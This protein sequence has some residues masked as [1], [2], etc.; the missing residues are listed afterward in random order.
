MKSI[1][2]LLL[3]LSRQDIKL[4]VEGGLLR[5]KAPQ[6]TLNPAI[7]AEIVDRK[8]EI[9][10]FLQ[11]TASSA[12]VQILPAPRD[13][14]MPLSFAQQRLWFIN[15]LE[16]N[17]STYN[18]PGAI[19]LTGQLD[20]VSLERTLQEIIRRHEALRTNFISHNG[21]PIQVIQ[22]NNAWQMTSIDLQD[23]PT[24]EREEK[25]Q[26][27]ATVDAEKP[28]A[29]DTDSLIRATLIIATETEHILLLTMH[30]I[31]S[32]GWSM[33]VLVEEIAVLYEAFVRCESSP[34]P[35][36]EIQYV[37]FA[38]WQRQWLQ[39]EILERQ[40]TYWQ[41]QL[42]NAP[43]LLE[44]PTDRPRPPVQ[45]FR[46]AEQ[47]FIIPADL[48]SAL[49]SLSR[50]EEVTLF[51]TLLAAFDILLARYTGQIDILIGSGIA[52]RHHGQLEGLI[53]FFVNTLVLRTDLSGNPSFRELLGRV[54][55]MVL[56][57]YDHQDLP[58][59]MLVDVLKPE[60]SPSH[61]P[62]FQVAFVL[63]NAPVSEI[64]LAGLTLSTLTTEH[65][66]AKLD[67]TLSLEQ[68]NDELIGSWEY[69]TDLF[70]DDTITR[71]AGHFQT[72]LAGIVADP[73][74]PIARL[75]LLTVTEQNQLLHE[76]N[77]TQTDYPQDRCVHQLFE[78]QAQQTPNTM[79]VVC[80]DRHLT[81]SELNVRANQLANYL[82]ELGVKPSMLVG[83]CVDRSID[84]IVGILGILKAGGAYVPLDPTY[85]LERLSFMLSD[86]QVQVLL[87][88]QQLVAGL[89]THQATVVC[90]DADWQNI[91]QHQL[92]NLSVN[93]TSADLAYIIYTSGSTGTPK[94]VMVSH[95]GLCNLAKA[96]IALFGI[97]ATSKIL[98]FASLSFDASIW[99][100]VMGLTSGAT[101]YVDT[102]E[103]LLPGHALW[104]YLHTRQITHVV[105]PPAALAVLPLEP[106]PH[107]QVII[108]G[109]EACPQE[110][111]AQWSQG[112]SFFNAYGPTEG[113]VCATV[114]EP[115]DGRTAT[116]IGRPIQNVEVYIFNSDLQPL[117]IGVS[118]ELHIG[119]AGLAQG[120]LNRPEL[121]AAKFIPHPFSDNPQARLYKTGD[122]AR[123]LPDGNIEYLGRI[124]HQVKIRGFRI[125]LEEIEALLGQYPGVQQTAVIAREDREHDKRLVAYVVADRHAPDRHLPQSDARQSQYIADWQNLY[126]Q[127]YQKLPTD[128]DLTFNIAGWNSSYT[129]SPIPAA[130]MK[131]WVDCTVEQ[132]LTL[133][134]QRVL[135]IG[136]GSG[137]LLSQ[138]APHCHEYWG[139]DYSAAALQ[140]IEQM[141]QQVAG[142]ENV[143]TL[144]R[145]ADDFHGIEPASFDTVIINSVVQYFPSVTYL[146]RVLEQAVA[147]VRAGGHVLIGDVRNLLLLDTYILSVQLHQ[148]SD[149][150]SLSQLQQ[151]VQQRMMQE[152]ELLVDPEFFLALQ[153]HLPRISHVRI[154]PKRGVYHNELTKFRYEVMLEIEGCPSPSNHATPIAWLDWQT[155]PLTVA[156]IRQRLVHTQPEIFGISHI[157]NGRV[158]TEMQAW[159]LLRDEAPELETVQDLRQTLS[160]SKSAGIDPAELWNLSQELSYTLNLSWSNSNSDG[161]YDAVFQLPSITTQLDL[162]PVKSSFQTWDLYGSNP[163]QGELAK[164]LIP[165]LR[166]FLTDKLPNY[167]VPSAFML[168]ETM[169]L[170]ANGKIDRRKLPVPEISRNQLAVGFVAPRNPTE[171]MLA[172]VWAE[173]L[174]IE[175]IGIYDNF[176]A[177]GGHSLLGTQLISRVKN[178]FNIDLPL[179]SLFEAAT[180][181]KLAE[182]IQQLQQT[183][184]AVSQPPIQV[185]SRSEPI[186]LS[187]AQQRLWFFDRL[188]PNSSAYNM[189]GAVRLQG[190]LDLVVLERALQEIVR[191]HEFLRTN[192][193]SQDGQPIQVIHQSGSWQMTSIDLQHLPVSTREEKIQQLAAV[194][195]EQPF[196]L[197]TDPLMRAKLLL[198][199]ATERILLLTMHHIISDGWS[200]G[201]FVK[202][203]AALYSAFVQGESSPLPELTIQYADFAVWQR[204]WLQGET[205]DR[206]LGY[207]QQQLA[208]IPELSQLPTDRPRPSVQTYQGATESFTLGQELTEQLQALSRQTD[209]T[210]FMTLLATFATLLYRY[211]GESD[212]VIGSPIANRNRS[213]I[214]SLIGF[215][216]N[217][218]VLRTRLEEHLSFEQL[219]KQVRATTLKAY[220]HQ[221]LSFEQ[222]VEALQPQRSMSHS[223]L[224]QVMFVLQNTPMGEIKLPGVRLSELNASSTIAKFDLALS[225]TETHLGLDC[226]WEYNTDLFD[227][228]TIERM[229]I[230]FENLLAAIVENPRQ[231]VSELPLLSET[232]R[233][234]LLFDWNDTQTDYPHDRCIHQLFEDQVTKTPDAIAVVF[235][236]QS[237]TY[238]QLNQRANQLAHHLQTLEVKPEVLVGI[239]VER[240]LEMVVG[241]LGILKAGGAYVPLDPSYPTERL[242]YMVSDAGIEVLL[243]Q[244]NLL[245]TLPSHVAQV[246]CLDTDGGVIE[247]HSPKNLV[248]DVRADNL[249]Y[250]IYTSGSTGEPKGVCVAH[251]S[252]V[253][254]VQN[255]NYAQFNAEQVFL[256][257][258][259]ITFD[260]STLELWGSLLHGSKLVIFPS[261]VPDLDLLVDVVYQHQITC[262]WLT[263]GLFHLMV[264]EY[265]DALSPVQ[266][267]LAGGDVLSVNHVQRF[268]QRYPNCRLIDGYGPTENTTFTCCYAIVGQTQDLQ[269]TVPIG[270]PIANTQVYI[271]DPQMQ[272]VPI[273]V[274]GELH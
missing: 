160:T 181:A 65:K 218:L 44:L 162:T 148:S 38:V 241:L 14:E 81:Y 69:N 126:E 113:T 112:R 269:Q 57:A 236:E 253:R 20:L 68:I 266:Q 27:L 219:L 8:A 56:P 161:G 143:T 179:H 223:P 156:E 133:R 197:D 95:R 49:H 110:L 28:F 5:Y 139:T 251:R 99:E 267:L 23:L 166:Q 119:G 9:L 235:E 146:L 87:T 140:Y 25:I 30:H 176:F 193:I 188:E 151:H 238:Q 232:E 54:Q 34:L 145:M 128:R 46:G 272:P 271:L 217:T 221:D 21:Q 108:V 203:I 246:V 74:Q 171:E 214:E 185:V 29:L 220:E 190:Q 168:L 105:L 274:A 199:S 76:W 132:I 107:L 144:E 127:N 257:L 130:E 192:F 189:P 72:V 262:L 97:Q 226:E 177:L 16:P 24:S 60:R 191:R 265:L 37:D 147:S 170:T 39:G 103:A 86:A 155:E 18:M 187:F 41:Q 256:Q 51:M 19:R 13:R 4:W 129:G 259:A 164:N 154:Q 118:G 240:S 91:E 229:A 202:E 75:P 124:D 263:A 3:D 201:L 208:D 250:V 149:Q 243:T 264:D 158:N 198:V 102:K 67:L 228:S 10:A 42:A 213:E 123:Y 211:S 242:S 59:E 254:L 134:P 248:T 61:S 237:L 80:G 104:D 90:L 249:A 120:Y 1:G 194:E 66:T 125:E 114:S 183:A 63:Q 101:L 258:A 89:P 204:Q 109:G 173:V 255:T 196:A 17:S 7:K 70:D 22:Q 77:D 43:A 83:I 40:L 207:W 98:Q 165:Q 50:Q 212:V 216:V 106:L 116:P 96:Q 138:I 12:R 234:Q 93:I 47:I 157:T 71:M 195:A 6:G 209:S 186:P 153:Q 169:P 215:F 233:Q 205:L 152:E 100:I 137:L 247:L 53:G 163:L 180:I 239:C 225:M 159:E 31:V 26:Q 245:S 131:E 270:R 244:E 230:H 150:L 45:T 136:C 33:G 36:L 58:F 11:D 167:M 88:Q 32:D 15:E 73:E 135:E 52:N 174:A 121:T 182:Y 172:Q 206:Q 231:T 260:A 111:I 222:I 2:K 115:L 268:R 273:G 227:K 224:F 175:H 94:G 178:A 48:T 122:L 85:P 82:V 55:A 79:A 184:T 200:M 64:E 84:M 142:L 261:Q 92:E 210:L 252:V 141:K 35:E 117:P 62:L 78:E